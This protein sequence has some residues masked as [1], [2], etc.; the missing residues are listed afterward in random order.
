M[1]GFS[2]Y[3]SKKNFSSDLES[4]TNA[5][6]HRGPDRTN[7]YETRVSDKNIGIGFNRLSIQDVSSYG[8][9]PMHY[10]DEITISFNGEIYNFIELREDLILKGYNFE[11]G[12]DTEVILCLYREH[13]ELLF[14]KLR[15]MFSILIFDR[16][17]KKIFIGRDSIGIKPF[18]FFYDNFS[19]F[20]S[21]EL[22]GL[23]EFKEVSW[24]IDESLIYEFLLN[25]FLF[26]PGTGYKNI[27]KVEP[28]KL[29][30]I[31]LVDFSITDSDFSNGL[32]FNSGKLQ[33]ILKKSIQRQ[34]RS[35]VP[36]GIFFSGGLDS[37]LLAIESKDSDLIF[38]EYSD[39]DE[40][41]DKLYSEKISDYMNKK[42]NTIQIDAGKLSKK[43]A[44]ENIS[45]V[46]QNTEELISDYTFLATYE[47]S[48]AAKK[49]GYKVMLSGMG[50]D[51]AFAGYPRYKILK[52]H[53]LLKLIHPFFNFLWKIKLIPKSF[54]KKIARL[55]N[56]SSSK[57][58]H[59]GYPHL[60]GFF[61]KKELR[62]MIKGYEEVW[63]DNLLNKIKLISNG[64]T[65]LKGAEK[66]DRKGF[67]SH[68]LMVSD[69]A[70]M[71]AS[72]ELRVPLLDEDLYQYGKSLP[73][74]R[75]INLFATKIPL[76]KEIEKHLPKKLIARP[77][78]GFNPPLNQLIDA[79][80]KDE[81]YDEL[82]KIK[83]FIKQDEIQ[84]ILEKHF[85]KNEDNTYKIWQL[86]YLKSWIEQC[87]D[88]NFKDKAFA[89]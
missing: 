81:L 40:N 9:Q 71:L 53:S 4:S 59:D 60:V 66:I 76:A 10:K 63:Q 18:Y 6:I 80:T 43:R 20:G 16:L 42:L 23:K 69:K 19:F 48:N 68:N 74:E 65:G 70:S 72:I 61:S 58:F 79:F 56:F 55:I 87:Y 24:E 21:S 31:D 54:T 47:L 62:N 85:S 36:L 15:G 7:I 8:D 2:F 51:E 89:K 30:E 49:A 86:L 26:E 64:S 84:N 50:G 44:L 67:L 41:L 3:A 73:A 82:S 38:A 12:S 32:K 52:Y 77:K 34:L 28:G 27:K 46:A 88:N 75:K 35:D 13:K 83:G 37:T 78:V 14:E 5:I 57:S 1:C 39:K 25:G 45:F 29:I 22:K 11:G 33:D 17:R